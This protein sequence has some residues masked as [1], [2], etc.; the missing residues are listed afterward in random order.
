MP[1]L[2]GRTALHRLS[3]RAATTSVLAT[4]VVLGLAGLALATGTLPHPRL[5][6]SSDPAT[7]PTVSASPSGSS[8]QQGDNSATAVNT[9][10]GKAVY[11]ISLKITQLSGDTLAPTNAAVAYASCSDCETVAIAL[12]GVLVYGDPTVNAP[13]NLAV[14]LNEDCTNCQTLAVAYQDVVQSSGRVRIT[15]AGRREIARIRADL[16][17]LRHDNLTVPEILARVNDDAAR[18][19][20]VLHDDVVPVGNP[21]QGHGP[22]SSAPSTTGTPTS[23]ASSS[24]SADTSSSPTGSGSPTPTATASPSATASPGG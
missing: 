14:A 3:R 4:L 16:N 1:R 11:A 20:A 22:G 5:S 24:P 8:G 6:S 19:L 9:Q 15:G 18:F 21:H 13:T 2:P 23:P 12:E 17:Q 7:E 10:D